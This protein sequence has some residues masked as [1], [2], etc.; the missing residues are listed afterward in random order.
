MKYLSNAR[1]ITNLFREA[2]VEARDDVIETMRH[3]L[4]KQKEMYFT[5]KQNEIIRCEKF[6]YLTTL[7]S[8]R[9]VLNELLK[10]ARSIAVDYNASSEAFEYSEQYVEIYKDE[11]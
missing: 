10:A 5:S 8:E 11:E 9:E 1:I 3:I 6:S 7:A 4:R 2:D